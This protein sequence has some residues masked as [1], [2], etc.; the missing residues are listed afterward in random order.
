MHRKDHG[1]P[2][3]QVADLSIEFA[4][5]R[6]AARVV[7][8]VSLEVWPGEI[9]GIIGESGSG[10]TLTALSILRM[11]PRGA[12]I[13]G[14]AIELDGR[15]VRDLSDAEMRSVRGNSVAFIPQD[16]MQAL[17]PTLRISRQVGEPLEI[18]KGFSHSSGCSKGRRTAQVRPSARRRDAR[19]RISAS[20]LGRHAA[21][22]HDRHGAGA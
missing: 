2:A 9:V 8:R 6:A 4:K 17:N 13:A 19:E 21:T 15:S 14:G 7:D 1:L 5:H 18:H 10:K 12:A 3:L 16:A 11:L 22:R 20:V